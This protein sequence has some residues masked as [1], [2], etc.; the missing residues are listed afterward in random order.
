MAQ[1]TRTAKINIPMCAACVLLCLTLISIHF[2]S[3]LYAKYT[4]RADG[5]D[6]ARVAVFDVDIAGD[7]EAVSVVCGKETDN[8]YTITVTNKSEVAVEY[9]LSCTFDDSAVDYISAVFDNSTG[10]LPV[11]GEANAELAFKVTDWNPVTQE[12]K[13]DSSATK[14]FDFTVTVNVVQID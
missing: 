8:V 2:T 7:T 6:A 9:K 12:V 10:S 4:A 3:G 11:G 13:N 14:D 5:G 1:H